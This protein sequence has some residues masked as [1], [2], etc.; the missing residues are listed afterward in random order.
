MI[1]D[2]FIAFC[3]NDH[4]RIYMLYDNAIIITNQI[5][6]AEVDHIYIDEGSVANI[7]ELSAM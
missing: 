2:T 7:L 1:N 4:I 6:Y 5:S 3:K